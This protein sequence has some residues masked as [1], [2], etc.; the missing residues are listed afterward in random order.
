VYPLNYAIG[1]VCFDGVQ[2]VRNN[3]VSLYGNTFWEWV[4]TQVK[5]ERNATDRGERLSESLPDV[6]LSAA[7]TFDN[8]KDQELWINVG[9]IVYVWNYGNN[10]VYMYDNIQA[11]CYNEI[12]GVIY[13][14]TTDGKIERFDGALNDNGTAINAVW[15][16]GFNDFGAY[17]YIK[18][19]RGMWFTIQ[20][21]TRTSISIKTPTNRKNEED[22]SIKTFTEGYVL[23]D[24][25][26][27]DFSDFT[28]KTNRNP[29]TFRIKIKAKKYTT[30]QFI[31]SNSELDETLVVL[32]FKV[33]CEIGSYSK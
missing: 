29:Q 6:D 21:A 33:A 16:S 5:D 1:N 8:Q 20:P 2:V 24:F 30:I 13:Y 31:F 23:F 7:V 12:G 28:F 15:K 18:T 22:P 25:A 10:T 32:S 26:N 11:N 19:S 17:E 14:G 27:I 4:S 3:P 9:S